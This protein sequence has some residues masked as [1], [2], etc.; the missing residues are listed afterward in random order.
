VSTET[1]TYDTI[2][3][4]RADLPNLPEGAEIRDCEGFLI[5]RTAAGG[6]VG[7]YAPYTATYETPEPVTIDPKTV[8]AGDTVTLESDELVAN[9]AGRVTDIQHDHGAWTIY[10][11]LGVMGHSTPFVVGVGTSWTLTAHTPAPKPEWA[12]GTSGT[13]TLNNLV[14][15]T[16][17]PGLRAMRTL[18]AGVYGFALE[19]GLTIAD[20][21]TTYSVSDFVPDEGRPKATREQVLAAVRESWTNDRGWEGTTDAVMALIEGKS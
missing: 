9:I 13:A 3:G 7:T 15:G 21:A 10:L 19:N 12:P 20:N 16:S 2:G 1:K 4:L 8:K 18:R 11:A 14:S 17:S 6:M 5:D